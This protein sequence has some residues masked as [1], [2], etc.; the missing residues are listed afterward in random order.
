VWR[1]HRFTALLVTHD[2][3]EA[4]S[5]ADRVVLVEDGEISF[6]QKIAL[7]RPRRRG[8]AGFAKLEERVLQRLL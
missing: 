5:L 3:A 8:D 2:V 4:V 1:E 6:D 7:E